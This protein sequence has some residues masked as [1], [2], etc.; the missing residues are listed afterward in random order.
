MPANPART[1]F[2]DVPA[3]YHNNACAFIF[4]DGHAEIHKWLQPGVIQPVTWAADKSPS[5]G[6]SQQS[7]PNDPDVLWMAHHT[8]APQPGANPW[9]P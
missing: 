8:T 9:Y 3:K 1:Y 7:V 6:N 2:I 5:I 4:A